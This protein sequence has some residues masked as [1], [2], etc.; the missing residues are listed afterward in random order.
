MQDWQD[1]EPLERP[2]FGEMLALLVVGL[3]TIVPPA[4][5][6]CGMVMSLFGGHG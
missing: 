3:L 5:W 1:K 6:V 4:A 2:G